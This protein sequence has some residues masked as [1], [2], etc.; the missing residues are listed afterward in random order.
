MATGEM[1]YISKPLIKVLERVQRNLKNNKRIKG[2]ATFKK[3]CDVVARGY[4]K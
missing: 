3:A 2:K 1:K 4:K